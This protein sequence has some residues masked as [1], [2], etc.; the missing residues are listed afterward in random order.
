M[1]TTVPDVTFVLL[2]LLM[3]ACDE[4]D[5]PSP[6]KIVTDAGVKTDSSPSMSTDTGDPSNQ[7]E[8]DLGAMTRDK[9]FDGEFCATNTDCLSGLCAIVNNRKG[10]TP[11]YCTRDCMTD[12]DCIGQSEDSVACR[13]ASEEVIMALSAIANPRQRKSL[14]LSTP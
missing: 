7:P 1:K 5:S 2:T 11:G 13:D 8:I 6:S 14:G 3:S 12:A 9:N 10:P 4:N